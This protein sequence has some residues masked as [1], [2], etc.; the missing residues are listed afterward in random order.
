MFGGCGKTFVRRTR[1]D[2]AN[3]ISE[4]FERGRNALEDERVVIDDEYFQRHA[5]LCGPCHFPAA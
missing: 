2:D 1:R 4:T 3:A 5:S